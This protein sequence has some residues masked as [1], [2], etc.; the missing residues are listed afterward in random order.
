MRKHVST[1]NRSFFSSLLLSFIVIAFLSTLLLTI[2][3]TMNY[4]NSA[5][6]ALK[7]SSQQLLSQ[8]NYAIDQMDKNIER[9]AI[10]C[11][12]NNNIVTYLHSEHIESTVPTLA[13]HDLHKQ[14]MTFPYIESIYLYSSITGYAYSSVTGYQQPLINFEDPEAASRLQDIAFLTSY[15]QCPVP[16]YRNFETDTAD[17]LS[18]YFPVIRSNTLENAIVI[19]IYTSSL[20]DSISNMKQLT[21]DT[22]SS[23]VILDKNKTY[24]TSVLNGNKK[25]RTEWISTVMD[26]ISLQK[27]LETSFVNLGGTYYY[28]VCTQDNVYGWYLLSYT[29]ASA[30][31]SNIITTSFIGLLFFVGVLLI[32]CLLC[33]HFSH[34]LNTPIETLALAL[35][36]KR[37]NLKSQSST[38]P[39]EF[40]KILSAI[41]SLQENN[42]HLHALQQKTKYSQTQD[43]LNGLIS[44]HNVDSPALM[45]Q[46]IESLDLAYL[47]KEKL[48]MAIIKIDKYSQCL[49]TQ[50]PDELWAIRF[51]VI[52][53]IEELASASFRCNAFS[54]ADDKFVLLMAINPEK[55]NI[56]MED[57][58][59]DILDT[60]QKNI[61]LHLHFTVSIA[62]STIF[63]GIENLPVVFS[64][65]ENSLLL[66]MRYG[67]N[68]IIDPYQ[69]EDIPTENFQLTYR[70][71]I[72]LIDHLNNGQLHAAWSDYQELATQLF[73]YNYSE[74]MS[75]IIHLFYSIYER[76]TEKYPML[77]DSFTQ[78]LKTALSDLEDAEISDDINQLAK[79]FLENVCAIV[80]KYKNAS[81]QQNSS[82]VVEKI[83][84]IIQQEY[85]NPALCLCSIA[86]QIGLSSNYAGHIFKQHTQKSVSQ[87]ILEI[88]ME[89]V[90]HYLQT[91][92]YSL[93]KILDKVGL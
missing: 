77:K 54:R 5:T 59:M 40:Q 12:S 78:T 67:H 90:A 69:S 56:F 52:N 84:R 45:A 26:T 19:N 15:R 70:G 81:T 75:T 9:I 2:V 88:R 22:D 18:Y 43:C 33:V 80:S 83:T 6:N 60:I 74:I 46:K 38:A 57:N 21:N 62:Y 34:R 31:F 1:N 89:Q 32:T 24:L 37:T 16:N 25:D 63:Y 76:L 66:K 64:N 29:P 27:N 14:I 48:C 36:E 87:Y 79:Y 71:I 68:C 3:L 58:I 55:N 8:T 7:A 10:S 13:S 92:S 86:D 17:I 73:S 50:N 11:M 82:V 35:N 61:S 4:L 23:F 47:G 49:S 42:R 85:T 93:D 72:Q 41:S 53:I 44:N 20:T 51:S 28:Q 39:K 91:T 65:T 30:I